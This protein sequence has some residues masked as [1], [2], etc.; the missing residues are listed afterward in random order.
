MFADM[1]EEMAKQQA[2]FDR[3]Q[4]Q[5]TLDRENA[6]YKQEELKHLNDQ[7]LT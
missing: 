2:L 4:E 1:K 3:D 7:L 6:T 5:V